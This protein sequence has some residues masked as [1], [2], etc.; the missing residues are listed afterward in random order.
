M[1]LTLDI[2][3]TQSKLAVFNNS[4]VFVKTFNSKFI[5]DEIDNF[6]LL[7]PDIKN[8]IVCSVTDINLN[9]EKYNF[10]NVHFVSAN[11]NIPFENLYLSKNLLGNDRIA[12]VSS[13]SISYP[14]KN[15]LVIDAGSCITYDFINDK[16]Q[17]LGGAISPGLKMRYKSLNEF[18]SKLPLVSVESL[19]KLIGNQTI[20]SIN[21][22]VVNG[23]VFEIEG[24]V[25][26]YL[27]EY[28]NLTVILTGGNSVFL[29]N[30]L[31]ISIF[32]NQNF[33]LEGLNNLIK[34]NISS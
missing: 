12:L 2:G 9:L 13:A 33:L 8:L 15:V 10:N 4:L 20:D 5:I 26:Q 19:D 32:A 31:K 21:V 24:F 17:Y 18:T 6:L 14:G 30:Q 23:L 28:D 11:S 27:S 22:G 7:Y 34:L 16:N 1:N 29:S 3:N 25:R